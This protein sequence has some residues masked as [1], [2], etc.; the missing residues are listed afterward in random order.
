MAPLGPP[1]DQ[2][3]LCRMRGMWSGILILAFGL[4]VYWYGYHT[5]PV[6]WRAGSALLVAVVGALPSPPSDATP[7]SAST[8]AFGRVHLPHPHQPQR[9]LPPCR[10]H[11]ECHRPALPPNPSA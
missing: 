3:R 9:P 7:S 2:F 5:D 11:A 6:L 1:G 4:F 8:P 10:P